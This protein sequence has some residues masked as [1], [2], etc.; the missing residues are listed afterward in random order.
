MI[1]RSISNFSWSEVLNGN[2]DTNWQAKTSKK[3]GYKSED[4]KRHDSY[5][6]ECL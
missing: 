3:H 1:R 2:P 4:K 6:E 5:R